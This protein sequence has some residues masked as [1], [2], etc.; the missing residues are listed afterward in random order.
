M[1]NPEM[2][3]TEPSLRKPQEGV[4]TSLKGRKE[5]VLLKNHELTNRCEVCNLEF[6]PKKSGQTCCSKKCYS[7]KWRVENLEHRKEYKKEYYHNGNPE[8]KEYCDMKSSLWLYRMSVAQYKD[9]LQKQEGHCALC[10]NKHDTNG[11]RL[12]VDHDHK[13]CDTR[14]RQATCGTCNR[15]L[16]CGVCNRKLGFLEK[17]LQ[18]FDLVKAK[19]GS[20]VFKAL[21]YI[22]RYEVKM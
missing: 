1:N 15:G 14:E 8:Y 11:Y 12:H 13:C 4:T 7:K 16:L 19:Q 6:E 10:D 20:W 5:Q 3:N 17:F 22:Y 2:E 21:Q 18:E 9:L